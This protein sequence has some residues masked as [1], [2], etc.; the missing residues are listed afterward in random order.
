MVWASTSRGLSRDTLSSSS[1]SSTAPA[2]AAEAIRSRPW[3]GKRMPRLSW[4]TPWPLRPTRCK[5]ED[6]EKGLPARIT[7]STLPMS[8]P[9]SSDEVAT[10]QGI[11]PSAR[12]FSAALR[13]SLEREPWWVNARSSPA[14]W[15]M[16]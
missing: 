10:T 8:I 5:A 11:F 13:R 6:A 4:P 9:S 2:T 15:L 12:A 14:V 1:L 7:S 3:N 16:R